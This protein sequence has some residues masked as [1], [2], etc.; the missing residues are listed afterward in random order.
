MLN[1]EDFAEDYEVEIIT[2]EDD[3][4]NEQDFEFL[5]VV[6]YDGDEYIIL[7]PVEDGE[8]ADEVM[9][10]RI[11]SIDDENENYVGIDD[12]EILQNVFAIFKDRY[13]DEFDFED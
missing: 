8:E 10:L 3:L 6:E 1:N 9:I 11:D 13:K 4:G 2:L 5:D 12:E 7:L